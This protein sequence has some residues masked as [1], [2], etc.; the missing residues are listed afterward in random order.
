MNLLSG[1]GDSIEFLHTKLSNF[2]LQY[3][4]VIGAYSEHSMSTI[5]IIQYEFNYNDLDS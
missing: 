3:L 5:C 4:L 1:Y 2:R